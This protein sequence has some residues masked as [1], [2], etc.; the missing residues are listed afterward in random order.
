MIRI[1]LP[2]LML[3]ALSAP[4][5]AQANPIA[6]VL[7][8]PTQAMTRKLTEQFGT[9]RHATGLRSPDEVVEIWTDSGGDW[10]MVI[11]YST[12]RSCIVAM[13][14]YWQETRPENPT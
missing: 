1:V 8:A 6:E 4:A 5:P 7:C 10:T 9:T 11:T 12:G 2:F 13:G 14:E 3:P